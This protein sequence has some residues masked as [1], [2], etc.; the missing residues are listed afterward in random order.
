MLYLTQSNVN[1]GT[2]RETFFA[3]QLG[4]K[5]QLTLAH[6]GDFMVNDAYT[7][8]VGGAGKSFHQI[9]GIKK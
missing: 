6:Q 8:E 9:A 3:N 4:I 1:I 2:I 5:H 7:F